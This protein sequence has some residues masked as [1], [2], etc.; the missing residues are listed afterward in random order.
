LK[1]EEGGRDGSYLERHCQADAAPAGHGQR[2][3]EGGVPER[4]YRALQPSGVVT[5][6]QT[7]L[8][9]AVVPA[10]GVLVETG[11]QQLRAN[12]QLRANNS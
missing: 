8:Y 1:K 10:E 2:R 9:L 7:E 6:S 11:K 3:E 12:K 5:S 4:G